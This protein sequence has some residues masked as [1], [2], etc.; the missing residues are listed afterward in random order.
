MPHIK[1]KKELEA[2]R[3]LIGESWY[4]HIRVR[5]T[6]DDLWEWLPIYKTNVW[7]FTSEEE[8][9]SSPDLSLTRRIALVFSDSTPDSS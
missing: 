7:I 8:V 1:T 2:F 5:A 6:L 4:Q 9:R 3:G